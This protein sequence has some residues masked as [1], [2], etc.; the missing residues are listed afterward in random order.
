MFYYIT[1]TSYTCTEPVM[2][3]VDTRRIHFIEFI[4][5]PGGSEAKSVII[6]KS[7]AF[8]EINVIPRN[9]V[10][11]AMYIIKQ[12]LIR[13]QFMGK[14]YLSSL[15]LLEHFQF[16]NLHFNPE[17]LY[18]ILPSWLR[19]LILSLM[20]LELIENDNRSLRVI[21]IHILITRVYPIFP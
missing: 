19:S 15:L 4:D 3:C 8:H 13:W 20:V 14:C 1:S 11:T 10:M 12:M 18:T 6:L 21:A 9:Q 2:D 7:M 16:I 17:A 5:C